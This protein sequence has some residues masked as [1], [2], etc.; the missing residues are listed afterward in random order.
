M[1]QNI[2]LLILSFFSIG[3]YSQSINK[4]IFDEKYNDSLLVGT[5]NISAFDK[6]IYLDWY[7]SEYEEYNPNDSILSILK[8]KSENISIT[9]V[10]GLWCSDSRREIPRFFKIIEL[11]HFDESNLNLIAVD[12]NKKAPKID[13]SIYNISLVPTFIFYKESQE[14]GRIRESPIT[15]L[16]GDFLNIISKLD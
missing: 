9:I 8:D 14:I 15:S 12:T 16:E 1:K 13:I 7:M 2:L 10:F 5:C 6:D 4:Q 3:S 11:L